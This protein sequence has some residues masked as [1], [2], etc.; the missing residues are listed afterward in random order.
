MDMGVL[1]VFQNYHENVTDEEVFTHDL[2]LGILAEEAGFDSVWSAEHHFDDYSMCPDNFA[3][4]SYLAGKTSRVKLGIGAAILPWNSPLRVVEKA[5]MLDQISG[6]RTL[7]G[8]GRGLAKMEYETF[9]IPMEEARDRFNEAAPMVMSGVQSGIVEGD[10]PMYPQKRAVCRPA[11]SAGVS[12]EGRLF[13]AAMSPDT[14]PIIAQMG[15]QMMTFMQFPF[16]KHAEIINTWKQHFRDAHHTEPGPPVIQDFVI[17]HEDE[18]EAR[19][20]A[21][22]HINRYFLSVIKHYDFAGK[23]WRETKGYETYQAGADMIREAGME[24]AADAYVE[25][26]IYGTPQQIIEKYAYRHEMIGDFLPNAAFSFG[27]LPLAEAEKSLKLFGEKVIPEV[28]K[29]TDKVP[30]EV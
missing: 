3:I 23:H 28:H 21:Y 9:G 24:A 27:G 4:L 20:L 29:M 13:G 5:I 8:L 11:P 15:L 2:K 22:A 12:W 1:L 30:A 17:C 10:G 16:E 25:A 18:E 6:G 7:L 26:N 14:V 19:R